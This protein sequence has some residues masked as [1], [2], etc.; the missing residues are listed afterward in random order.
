MA[1]ALTKK[2]QDGNLY[3]RP[4]FVEEKS[5]GALG[6]DLPTL[7]RRSQVT[8]KS[9]PDFLPLECLVH[10][11]REFR[12]QDDQHAMSALMPVLLRRC[13]SILKSKVPD[14]YLPMAEDVREEILGEFSLLFA[15]DN[16][17]WGTNELDYYECRFF[18]AFRTFRMPIVESARAEREPLVSLPAEDKSGEDPDIDEFLSRL[19][20]EFRQPDTQINHASRTELLRAIETLP[21]DQAKAVLLCYFF[22]FSEESEDPSETTAATLC[23]VTGRT[24]RNRLGR[25]VNALS[26]I[27]KKE[28]LCQ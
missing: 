2:D 1:R 3:T 14:D 9:N 27:L 21:R 23:G 26:K 28:D 10:L 18:H 7:L 24:I 16:P 12:R 15:E 19:S 11:I 17:N 25:A 4:A 20:E 8:Q 6:Q 13:E 5:D 22:G